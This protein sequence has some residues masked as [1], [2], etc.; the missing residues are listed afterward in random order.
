MEQPLISIVVPAYNVGSYI[1]QCVDSVVNQTYPNWELLLVVGG[2]D[3]TPSIC[4]EYAAKDKRIKSIHDN[5]GLVP[6]RNVGFRNAT[7]KWITYLDGD[8]WLDTD[9][10]EVL[11]SH[12]AKNEEAEIVFWGYV[13]ELEGKT[14]NKWSEDLFKGEYKYGEHECKELAIRTLIYKYGLSDAWAK[15]IK[16]DYA[17]KH[18]IFHDERLMQGS[19]GVEFS[20]RAFYYAKSALY[21]KRCFYHYRYAANSI[22]KKVDENNTKYLVDCYRVMHEDIEGFTMKEQFLAAFYERTT[23]M[24]MAIAMNTYFSPLNPNSLLIKIAHYA[25]VIKEEPLFHESIRK[26]S[27]E[28]MDIFRKVVLVIL[29]LRCYALLAPIAWLKHFLLKRGFYNY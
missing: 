25:K 28:N 16:M 14:V 17:K 2:Q 18:G 5:K 24:L 19:E 11:A 7:G 8:D 12:I 23:Y 9:T 10:C 20:L 1:R 6:A 21:I 15:L 4:D 3:D 27:S 22:S 13:Q 29:R 26:T